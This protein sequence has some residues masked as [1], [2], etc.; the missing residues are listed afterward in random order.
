MKRKPV[1]RLCSAI[2][3][4]AVLSA[5]SDSGASSSVAVTPEIPALSDE[6]FEA[7]DWAEATHSNDVDPNYDE[8]FDDTLVKRF[9]FVVT[10]DR[11]QSMLDDMTATYGEFGRP[12]GPGLV[13]T[14]ED[15]IFVPAD[16][17]YIRT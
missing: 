8:V 14:D 9:D 6:D 17:Y 13:D 10:A 11:W 3:I 1:T 15:P 2:A 16:V 12:S 5:C 4:L 7:T